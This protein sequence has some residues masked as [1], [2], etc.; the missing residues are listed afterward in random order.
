MKI[1]SD[2]AT[3]SQ[4]KIGRRHIVIPGARKMNVVVTK[5]SAVMIDATE[6]SAKPTIQKSWPSPVE[7]LISESGA[8]AVQPVEAAPSLVAAP[9]KTVR[10]PKR[11]SQYDVAFSRGN[12]ISGAPICSGIK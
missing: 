12:A 8:Y 5:L 11:N 2:V 6:T 10:P 3:I 1:K 7:M 4:V 9:A